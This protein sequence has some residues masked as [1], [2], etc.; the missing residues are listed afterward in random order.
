VKQRKYY[1]DAKAVALPSNGKRET[2]PPFSVWI[3]P[4]ISG[5]SSLHRKKHIAVF[6]EQ[7]VTLPIQATC[8]PNGILLDP[9]CGSGTALIAAVSLRE[10]RKA[11]GIDISEEAL[12]EAQQIADFFENNIEHEEILQV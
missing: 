12:R 9:F 4:T 2:K 6:P 5:Q 7:L 8:P 1:F 10:E 3:V 11:I